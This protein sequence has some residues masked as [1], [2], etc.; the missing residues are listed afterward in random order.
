MTF[1]KPPLPKPYRPND[2]GETP[3]LVR[4]MHEGPGGWVGSWDAQAIAQMLAARDAEMLRTVAD[5]LNESAGRSPHV[6]KLAAELRKAANA[7]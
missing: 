7:A 6:G 3:C 5:W 4:Y 1:V 2:S